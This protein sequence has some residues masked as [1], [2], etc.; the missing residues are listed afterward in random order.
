MEFKEG[1]SVYTDDGKKAGSLRRVVIDPASE[2]VTHIVIE[3]GLLFKNDWVVG[4]DKVAATSEEK[5][6]LTCSVDELKD[7]LPLDVEEDVPLD[8]SR[9][10]TSGYF[11]AS[12]GMFMN[13]PPGEAM[14]KKI[15]RTIPDELVAMKEGA[16]VI[17]SDEK[18]VGSIEHLFTDPKTGKITHFLLYQ[19]T[20]V[21]T[22]KSIP[23]EWVKLITDDEVYLTVEAQKVDDLPEVQG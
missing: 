7:M 2:K 14:I 18:N 19:G 16:R 15:T 17:S 5:V 6:A 13:P 11:P 10:S 1:T 22:R 3:K 21:K 12:G 23:F 20:L 8:N 4:M 9:G